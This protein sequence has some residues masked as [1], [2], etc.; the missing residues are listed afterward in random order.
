MKL[1]VVGGN[2]RKAGKTLVVSG[3]IRGLKSLGWT[4]VKITPHFHG[5]DPVTEG[6]PGA[7]AGPGFL[8]TEERNPLAR[9]DTGRY[10]AAGARRALL[11]RAQ[12]GSLP[13]ALS[14]L[15]QALGLSEFVIIES[16]S[17]L[18]LLKPAVSVFVYAGPEGGFK[19]SARRALRH[20]DALAGAGRLP[21]DAVWRGIVPGLIKTRPRFTVPG[22]ERINPRLCRFVRG[23]LARAGEEPGLRNPSPS[24]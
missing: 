4:A 9:G 11:L 15:K 7:V 22:G 24:L 1:V 10:L 16:N 21:E 3:I 13:G 23:K 12:P 8:L 2:A 18:D 6:S 19:K 5:F 14:A 20:A 17:I